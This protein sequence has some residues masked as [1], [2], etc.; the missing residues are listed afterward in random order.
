MPNDL[1][2]NGQPLTHFNARLRRDR[3]LNEM[4]G[5]VK[6]VVVDGEVSV[7]EAEFL[8]NWIGAN[9]EA[10]STWPGKAMAD[11]LVRIFEDGVV[12][13]DERTDLYYFLTQ[14]VGA[15]PVQAGSMNA[16]TKLP[17]DDPPP[18]ISFPNH[19][20]V[21]TG[22]FVWGTRSDCES[23]VVMR[24][25]TLGKSITRRTGFLV[26]GDLGSRDWAHTS[27]GRKIEK[28]V[29]YRE[30]GVSIKIIDEPHWCSY[31]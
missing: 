9:A 26:L 11:R 6:G 24:G 20:F 29:E 4:L 3:A 8:A 19:E 16:A 2:S 25:G 30:A 14:L 1:D 21:F 7:A 5:L 31:L 18:L 13:D 15:E 17:L 10:I 27:F 12:S 28:A 22:K 23:A